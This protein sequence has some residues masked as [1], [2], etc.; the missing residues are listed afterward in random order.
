MGNGKSKNGKL[1]NSKLF[2]KKTGGK[3]KSG[4]FYKKYG[5][6][7]SEIHQ[8]IYNSLQEEIHNE[9]FLSELYEYLNSENKSN[10]AS[11]IIPYWLVKNL[12][13]NLSSIEDIQNL[14]I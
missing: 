12:L 6:T 11:T 4:I 14:I 7:L 1:K 5:G 3:S 9:K 2:S 10:C 8:T 13:D